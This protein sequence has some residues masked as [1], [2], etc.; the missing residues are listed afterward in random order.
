MACTSYVCATVVSPPPGL[1]STGFVP[2]RFAPP[3]ALRAQSTWVEQV[4]P[5][6]KSA[7]EDHWDLQ[8][9]KTGSTGTGSGAQTP[10]NKSAA[11]AAAVLPSEPVQAVTT[12]KLR[13]LPCDVTGEQLREVLCH[14]GFQGTYDFMYLPM[15]PTETNNAGFAFVNFLNSDLGDMFVAS[16]RMYK[17]PGLHRKKCRA[18]PATTQGREA[19]ELLMMQVMAAAEAESQQ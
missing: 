9:A 19:N 8:S 16:F 6:I 4:K 14:L 5:V 2:G 10:T 1:E 11:S 3:A 7:G 18:T 17:F 15:D 13:N 12:Y